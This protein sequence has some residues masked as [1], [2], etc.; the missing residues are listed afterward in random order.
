[1]T[2]LPAAPQLFALA[3]AAV[4]LIAAAVA[5]L[6]F[7]QIPNRHAVAVAL[8]F[9]LFALGA[10]LDETLS[11]LAVGAAVFALG[12]V[13]FARSWLGGGDV[14]LLAAVAL[15]T[16]PPLLAGFALATSLAGAGLSIVML[17]P[18]RRCLPPPPASLAHE[19]GLRQPVPFAIAI[20]TGGLF[21]LLK[22]L[23]D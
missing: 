12:I 17:T 10:D 19:R 3:V 2:V 9:L 1:M 4:A 7:Y 18:L 13:L 23:T 14:K 5:D 8:A 20:A 6:R 21:V 22:R 11:A 16:P 15:W